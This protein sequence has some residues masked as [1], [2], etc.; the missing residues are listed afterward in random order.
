M[1]LFSVAIGTG[2]FHIW[3]FLC[4][5]VP[6]AGDLVIL[7][8]VAVDTLYVAGHMHINVGHGGKVAVL[9]IRTAGRPER[10]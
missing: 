4:N 7:G 2:H 10:T 6:A 1:R 3:N 5:H 9:V 8:Y